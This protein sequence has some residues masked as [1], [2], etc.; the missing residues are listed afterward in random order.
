AT[1]YYIAHHIIVQ[2]TLFLAV[3]LIERQGGT[4]SLAGLGGMLRAAPVIAVLFFVPMLNLGGIPPFS[5]FIGKLGLFTVAAELGTPEAYWLMGIGALVSLLTLYALAR[6]WVLA[7]WRPKKRAEAE[8]RSMKAPTTEAVLLLE[9]E[10]ALLERLQD[11]PGATPNQE[12]KDIPRLM[13]AATGGM[14]A[15]SIALTVFAGPL[16]AYADRAGR[17]M[18]LPGEM[19]ELVLGDT[20]GALGGGSGDTRPDGEGR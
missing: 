5:G 16:Y 19:V 14:V 4:T 13:F 2:T 6:A 11:A 10:E 18:A 8:A 17:D 12:R 20:P 1:I 3:G 7:F 15:V 9:R